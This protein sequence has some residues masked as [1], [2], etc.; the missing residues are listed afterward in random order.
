VNCFAEVSLYVA[1]EL[2]YYEGGCLAIVS[3]GV[4]DLPDILGPIIA[5][6][7]ATIRG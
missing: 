7:M 6:K 1:Q 3:N 4:T 2:S 5:G